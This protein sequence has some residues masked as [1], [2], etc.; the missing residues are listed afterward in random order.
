MHPSLAF[1]HSLLGQAGSRRRLDTPAL[2]L[3]LDAFDHNVATMAALARERGIG[4]RPHA[5][6]HKSIAIG[7]RQ[8]EA[9]AVGLC[10]AKLGEAE[11]L[12]A[13]GLDRL[14]LTSPVLGEDKIR[15]LL[16]LNATTEDLAVVVD[17]AGNAKELADA[18]VAAGQVLSVLIV[19]DVGSHRFGVTSEAAAVEIGRL[20]AGRPSLRFRGV[21]GYAGHVQHIEDY[22]ERREQSHAA[23]ARLGRIRDAL[24]EAGSPSE[25]VTGSGTGS[26]DFDHELGIMTD[27]QVGSYIFCDVQYDQVVMNPDNPR[28]FRR[29]LFVHTRV[30][31][32]NQSGFVTTD[33]GSKSFAMDGP[34]PVIV[35]GAPE[36]ATYGRFGDEFG[37]ANLPDGGNL[38]RG[39][40]IVCE[41]PHCDPTVNL[42]DHYHC[43]RGNV[44]VDLW[45]VDARG[46]AA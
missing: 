21:Q 13:G 28:P 3:D 45:P 23:V 27:L 38:A 11:A 22:R 12:A 44:L 41:V 19:A 18:A 6:T 4:L 35:A 26:H 8:M 30:V 15:R 25:I 36:G 1:N 46:R 17:D 43:V 20:I 16:A 2:V 31:S 5:K 32:A 14:L 29:S 33:A 42:Y 10:C 9:G 7:R 34:P 37:R 40:L 24:A 39:T